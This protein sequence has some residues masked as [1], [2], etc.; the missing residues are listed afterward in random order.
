[1]SYD[2]LDKISKNENENFYQTNKDQISKTTLFD[3]ISKVFKIASKGLL[4]K[5]FLLYNLMIDPEVPKNAKLA[6]FSGLTYFI[7]PIDA[8]PDFLIGIGFTDD[9]S[10]LLGIIYMFSTH[11]TDEHKAKAKEML[12]KFMLSKK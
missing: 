10:V 3:K 8:I 12:E 11:I 7:M 9:M 2:Y 5:V 6:I 1:M 4:E